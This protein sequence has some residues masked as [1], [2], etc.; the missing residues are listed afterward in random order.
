MTPG[1]LF[2]TAAPLQKKFKTMGDTETKANFYN[3]GFSSVY[4]NPEKTVAVIA[5]YLGPSFLL[6]ALS[7]LIEVQELVYLSWKQSST[8]LI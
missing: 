7:S 5:H 6:S 2:N 3:G 4:C 1:Y 8:S